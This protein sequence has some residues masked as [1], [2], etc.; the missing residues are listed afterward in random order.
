MSFYQFG[1]FLS[2]KPKKVNKT[3]H[4]GYKSHTSLEIHRT[5][6][7]RKSHHSVV[8]S[9][10][11][12]LF[13]LKFIT[14]KSVTLAKMLQLH[15]LVSFFLHQRTPLHIAAREG[16]DKTVEFLIEEGAQIDIKD[17]EGVSKCDYTTDS[18]LVTEDYVSLISKLLLMHTNTL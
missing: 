13:A 8:G 6:R 10:R 18:R 1:V 2:A 14:W 17:N 11:V 4:S 5:M 15:T 3:R 9:L 12:A 7:P 16:Y